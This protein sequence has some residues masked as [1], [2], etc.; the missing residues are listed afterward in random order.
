MHREPLAQSTSVV[1]LNRL[2]PTSVAQVQPAVK[3][4]SAAA[5]LIEL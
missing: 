1:Q 3:S 5:S 4:T 2:P